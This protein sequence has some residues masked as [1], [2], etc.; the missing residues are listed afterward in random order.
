MLIAARILVTASL[1]LLAAC[2]QKGD[3]FL[4][5]EPAA[6]NRATLPQTLRPGAGAPATSAAPAASTPVRAQ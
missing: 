2:G 6:Q 4:P 5:T 3:L 1:P